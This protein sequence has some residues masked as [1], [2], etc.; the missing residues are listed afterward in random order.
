MRKTLIFTLAA[1]GLATVAAADSH[2]A[3]GYSAKDLLQPCFDA[4]NDARDGIF[5]EIECEQYMLG[6]VG[7]L[8]A[9]GAM[10]GICLPEQN[11]AD[12]VRW[13][14][15]RWIH[16]SYTARTKLAAEDAVFGSLK[17]NFGCSN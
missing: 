13:S 2:M 6:F 14:Y 12:E 17:D 3:S 8:K 7:A 16:E 9:A 1:M 10:D 11:V 4:D 15:M 5:A